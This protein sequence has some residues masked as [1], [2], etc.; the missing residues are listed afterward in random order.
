[1]NHNYTMENC[2]EHSFHRTIRWWTKHKDTIII[3]DQVILYKNVYINVK[4]THRQKE[5]LIRKDHITLSDLDAFVWEYKEGEAEES[6]TNW[7]I[8]GDVSDEVQYE[9]YNMLEKNGLNTHMCG[10]NKDHDTGYRLRANSGE[11][12]FSDS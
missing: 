1:M 2:E 11:L 10:W 8:R 5:R 7:I 4:M 9:V 3:I 12:R 6:E